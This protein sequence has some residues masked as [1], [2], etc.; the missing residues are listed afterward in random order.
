MNEPEVIA[1]RL[2]DPILTAPRSGQRKL[3]ALA[4]P[5]ASGKS[6]LAAV[7][8][9]K[10]NDAGCQTQ[11][12]PMDGFHLDNAIL[13]QRGLLDR[14]GAPETFDLGGLLRLVKA[15]PDAPDIVYPTFDRS[16]DIAIA[17]SGGLSVECD[18]IIVEGNYLLYDAPG[19][20]MLNEIWDFSIMLAVAPDVL[21]Q[22][23]VS[24]W[25]SHGL[26]KVDAVARAEANDLK[27]AEL[28]AQ[29]SSA[30]DI[31]IEG[32]AVFR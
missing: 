27:N 1:E 32:K 6:T 5:P 17:G 23:L 2:L 29:T 16:R 3:V 15:L 21:R 8:A 22:R 11:V 30:A 10:L 20:R 18:T 28:V 12:V 24:R 19:W 25:V 7:L 4:G 26:R 13:T 14:K 9:N 31:I